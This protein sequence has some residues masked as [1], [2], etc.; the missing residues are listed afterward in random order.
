MLVLVLV[1]VLVNVNGIKIHNYVYVHEHE[2]A[3]KSIGGLP[4]SFQGLKQTE[5]ILLRFFLPR[6][7]LTP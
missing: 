6:T 5:T 3:I 7:P 1:L 2:H 4:Y